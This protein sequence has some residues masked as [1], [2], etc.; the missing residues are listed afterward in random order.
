M[1]D[2]S[3]ALLSPP[4]VVGE[5][6]G[7]RRPALARSPRL[8]GMR[9]K[10]FGFWSSLEIGSRRRLW[11][12]RMEEA[13]M[14]DWQD[15][16][17]ER[18]GVAADT[19]AA[20]ARPRRRGWL[21]ALV[22]VVA[23]VVVVATFGAISLARAGV[24]SMSGKSS[25]GPSVATTTWRVY[26]DPLGLFTMR[27]PPGWVDSGG[28]GGA[29]TMGDRSGSF[30]GQTEEISFSDPA[31]GSASARISVNADQINSAFG[32]QWYCGEWRSQEGST[33]NGFAA[34]EMSPQGA[35]WM[36]ESYNAH[37]QINVEIPG[38]LE[39]PHSS[40]PMMTPPPIPTPLPQAMVQQDRTLL[41][42]SLNSFQP[43]ARPLPCS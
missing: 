20:P 24:T 40:P 37:F 2:N 4:R 18:A 25:L 29:F 5:E 6:R 21:G 22:A 36:F 27:V 14:R 17:E 9:R 42:S 23:L 43:A 41:N 32:R 12:K 35:G 7:G 30:S 33:F 16:K 28:L 19:P 15:S 39:G 1:M 31:L 34:N 10:S 3:Q 11:L 13:S 8:R 38:V 26:H